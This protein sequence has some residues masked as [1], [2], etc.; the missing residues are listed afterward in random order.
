MVRFSVSS[1]SDDGFWRGFLSPIK[2]RGPGTTK[3][4]LGQ[5]AI[6][7]P[8]LGGIA[9]RFGVLAVG[10]RVDAEGLNEGMVRDVEAG[11]YLVHEG[12]LGRRFAGGRPVCWEARD[13]AADAVVGDMKLPFCGEDSFGAEWVNRK[14]LGK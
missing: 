13:G 8:G 3:T 4:P 11:R 2:N 10:L 1:L 5:G 7:A 9:A 6:S 12:W 14:K